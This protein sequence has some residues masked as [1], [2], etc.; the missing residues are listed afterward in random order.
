MEIF[1][2]D[3]N[4]KDCLN[5]EVA[6]CIGYF[7]GLHL[8]HQ[9]LISKAKEVAKEKTIASALITFDLDPWIII[10]KMCQ[11]KY[12]TTYQKR[13]EMI[14]KFGIEHLIVLHFDEAMAKLTYQEFNLLL[15]ER[16]HIDTM[17]CGFDFHY[18]YQGKGDVLTLSSSFPTIMIE[19]IKDTGEKIS[20][21]R[22][23]RC[24]KQGDVKQANRLLN[25]YYHVDGLV[26][27]GKQKGRM[28]G[29]PTCNLAVDHKLLLPKPGVYLGYVKHDNTMYKAMINIGHNPTFNLSLTPSVEVYILDFSQYIYDQIITVYFNE[30]L[31]DEYKF[32]SIEA[33]IEQLNQDKVQAFK[34]SVYHE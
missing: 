8:G 14:E 30:Y 5:V 25:Y 9:A 23:S 22:I 34:Q 16:L 7:D 15:K 33:L 18:G 32:E 27:K 19:E 11:Y 6:A 13:I 1:H 10:K 31:R 17:I 26:V 12:L 2:L 21:T 4:N 20:S 29:F 28:I 3:L 24:L